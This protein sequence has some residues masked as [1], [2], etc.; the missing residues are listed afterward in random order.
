MRI[1]Y[2][3]ALVF[4]FQ[5]LVLVSLIF[6]FSDRFFFTNVAPLKHVITIVLIA[7]MLGRYLRPY[8]DKKVFYY[9]VLHF[10]IIFYCFFLLFGGY[11]TIRELVPFI[12]YPSFFYVGLCIAE[13]KDISLKII[14]FLYFLFFLSIGIA[15][16]QKILGPVWLQNHLGLNILN[17]PWGQ[18]ASM[19]LVKNAE[20]IKYFRVFSF[21]VDHQSFS[22]FLILVCFLSA[23]LYKYFHKKKYL[24]YILICLGSYFLTFSMTSLILM[25]I[26]LILFIKL[27]HRNLPIFTLIMIFLMFLFFLRDMPIIYLH[28]GSL[29]YRL[30]YAKNAI[31]QISFS[32]HIYSP[33]DEIGFSADCLWLWLAFRWG[34]IFSVILLFIIVVPGKF[35]KR[36]GH[37]KVY[38]IFVLITIIS[39]LSNGAFLTSTVNIFFWFL[40]GFLAQDKAYSFLEGRQK[41]I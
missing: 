4:F 33:R 32:P 16:V 26:L 24:F 31:G 18:S 28:L 8:I 38:S 30:V 41:V 29:K 25:L 20:D 13:F 21:F 9:G 27:K 23:L 34:I 14:K 22:A 37:R 12:I 36:K 3:N 7:M 40:L 39:M 2:R 19:L 15:V 35:L 1:K 6:G 10:L 17:R 11:G 5:V